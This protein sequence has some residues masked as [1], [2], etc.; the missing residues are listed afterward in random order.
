MSSLTIS[1]AA[2]RLSTNEIECFLLEEI[3]RF[4]LTES[5]R[6]PVTESE[7]FPMAGIERFLLDCSAEVSRGLFT[8]P[9]K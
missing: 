8:I 6:C 1:V 3:E 9:H 5:E 2:Q 7:R 4:P